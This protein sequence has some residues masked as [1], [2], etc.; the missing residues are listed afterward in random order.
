[1]SCFKA[2][3]ISTDNS[4]KDIKIELEL[5]KNLFLLLSASMGMDLIQYKVNRRYIIPT[6]EF[7]KGAE[8]A[9]NQLMFNQAEY[10]KY[11]PE[12]YSGRHDCINF[13]NTIIQKCNQL[14]NEYGLET[15]SSLVLY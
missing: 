12:D 10:Q 7:I 2:K 8:H 11:L 3:L 15:N 13:L 9:V 14:N 4:F 5:N 1:M 6:A